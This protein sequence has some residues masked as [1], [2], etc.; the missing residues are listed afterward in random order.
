MFE[1]LLNP[2]GGRRQLAMSTASLSQTRERGHKRPRVRAL[3]VRGDVRDALKAVEVA[4]PK[5]WVSDLLWVSPD[6]SR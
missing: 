6:Q 2:S 3:R 1:K 4:L 5:K